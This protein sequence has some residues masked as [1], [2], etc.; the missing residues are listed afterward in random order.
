ME[1]MELDR[2]NKMLSTTDVKGRPYVEVNERIKGFRQ[3]YPNG[4]IETNIEKLENGT[5][6]M[7]CVVKDENGKVLSKAHA[8]EKENSTFINKTSYIENCCTSATGR[9]LGY[10]GIG[11]DTSVASAEEVGNAIAQ[12]DAMKPITTQQLNVMQTL[13]K[14]LGDN[15]KPF[16]DNILA[17]YPIQDL[18][19]LNSDQYGQIMLEI[20]KMKGE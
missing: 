15:A 2:I 1:Y 5:V 19:E 9:A 14:G 16:Y 7:S 17:T 20:K 10:L 13:I 6:V 11:I 4:S 12:Q 18:K 3:L 8:Y